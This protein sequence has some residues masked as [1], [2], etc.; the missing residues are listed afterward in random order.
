MCLGCTS[1]IERSISQLSSA[2]LETL[3][4]PPSTGGMRQVTA[5]EDLCAN[6][7][8]RAKLKAA[9]VCPKGPPEDGDGGAVVDDDVLNQNI[10]ALCHLMTSNANS[11]V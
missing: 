5:Y 3:K 11:I 10:V 6:L 7:L 8:L 1:E 9:K 2:S 4:L